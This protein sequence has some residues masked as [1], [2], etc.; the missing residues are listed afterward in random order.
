MIKT[1]LNKIKKSLPG[2]RMPGQGQTVFIA[3]T[4]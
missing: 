4:N 1:K 2:D 3:L